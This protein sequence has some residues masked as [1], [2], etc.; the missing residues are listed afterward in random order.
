MQPTIRKYFFLNIP[1]VHNTVTDLPGTV[2]LKRT[3]TS[4][5]HKSKISSFIGSK[6][7]QKQNIK[8]GDKSGG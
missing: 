4:F 5:F 8:R 6:Y 2:V 3:S 1:Q 7:I